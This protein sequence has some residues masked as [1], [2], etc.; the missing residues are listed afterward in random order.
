MGARCIRTRGQGEETMKLA[1]LL[2]LL[3]GPDGHKVLINPEEVT[4]IRSAPTHQQSTPLL[5]EKTDCLVN[6][7]DGKFITVVESCEVV[8]KLLERVK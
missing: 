1:L 2:V 3:H 7:A 5:S 6:L 4:S 8:E